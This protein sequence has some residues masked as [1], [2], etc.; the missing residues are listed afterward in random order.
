MPT[1]ASTIVAISLKM[2]FSY[3]R[4][5]EYSKQLATFAAEDAGVR[6]GATELV[7]LP[8]FVSIASV[9]AMSEGTNVRVGAQ[10]LAAEDSGAFTGEVSGASV[11]I[12][13]PAAA[14]RGAASGQAMA[15]MSIQFA[16]N[17]TI[18]GDMGGDVK[19]RVQQA[20]NLSLRELEQMMRRVQAE[21][22]RRAF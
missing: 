13:A 19:G 4:T 8:T 17:I 14:G 22:Q 21:Q 9:L 16:P 12:G 15:G 18:G 20:M 10:D 7:V 5:L 6:T 2:Y 11:Q 1:P 3:A